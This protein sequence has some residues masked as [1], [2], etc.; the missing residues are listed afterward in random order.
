VN[1]TVTGN[2]LQKTSGLTRGLDAGAVSQQVIGDGGYMQFTVTELTKW[3]VIGLSHS[4]A[5]TSDLEIQYS[6]WLHDGVAEVRENPT[7]GVDIPQATVGI[8]VGD[9][10]RISVNGGVVKY[11]KNGMVFYTSTFAPTMPL[12]VDVTLLD[13]NSI[14]SNAVVV[15]GS[16]SAPESEQ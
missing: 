9:V 4:S 14:I 10:L 16:G 13:L 15:T 11:W 2:D 3:R 8:A 6:F 1:S 5:G 12:L 7:F